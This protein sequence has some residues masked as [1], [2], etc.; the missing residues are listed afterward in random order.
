M[1]RRVLVTGSEGLIGTALRPVLVDA[2][3]TVDGLDLRA[4]G[5]DHG[6]IRD[7]GRVRDAVREVDGIV[8][9][10]AV[11]RVVWGEQDPATCRATNVGALHALLE[12]VAERSTPPWVLFASS[13]EVYG[14]PDRLPA[15]EDAPLGPVNVYGRSKVEG[16][17]AIREA[18]ESGLRTTAV[19]LSNVYGPAS[20]HA[21]RVVPAFAHAAATG[22]TL[23]V[24]GT[25]NTFDFTHVDDV[26]RGLCAAV[27]ALHHGTTLP[28]MHLVSGVPTTLGDLARL[29]VSTA[30]TDASIVEERPRDFDVGR[31]WGRPDRAAEVLGWRAETPLRDGLARLISEYRTLGASARAR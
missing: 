13:R 22:G 28:T 3:F 19:R 9:L 31:F 10:A 11:S 26:S 27:E 14:Q 18:G 8:H 17:R 24:E 25:D 29:A 15:G 16:E 21:D 4:T 6:D 2:G 7:R 23:R 12:A 20:D 5:A 30:G 1:T